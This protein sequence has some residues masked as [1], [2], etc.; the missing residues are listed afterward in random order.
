M[1]VSLLDIHTNPPAP[2][3]SQPPLEILESGTGHGSLTLHLARAIHAANTTPPPRPPRSQIKFPGERAIRPGEEAEKSDKEAIANADPAQQE[4]DAWRTQRNAVIHTV[5]VSAK[6]SA[7]AEKNVR[8]FRRG[9]YAGDVDFYVGRVEDWIAEQYKKRAKTGAL[10]SLTGSSGSTEPFL[11]HAILD[12]PSAHARIPH[13]AP[14]MR[15]DGM[16]VVFMPSIT[17]IGDCVQLIRR[18]RLPFVQERVVEL[19]IGMTS[20]RQWDVRLA[21]KK[22]GADPSSWGASEAETPAAESDEAT[23]ADTDPAD[24]VPATEEA[25]KEEESVMVCRP[26]VGLRTMG[27]GFVGIWRRIEDSPRG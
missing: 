25:P 21:T 1:I 3:E 6:Y 20:G 9:I 16:L 2:D 8:G 12:M 26:K 19:G 4:W 14:I 22:S 23:S 27:G 18:L 17:Q 5:D 11:T 13:V 7:L 10:A 24:G 15:R